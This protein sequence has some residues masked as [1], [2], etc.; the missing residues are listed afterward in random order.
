M[1]SKKTW[2]RS[3]TWPR[4]TAEDLTEEG[5]DKRRRELEAL[6]IDP[7]EYLRRLLPKAFNQDPELREAAARFR[8]SEPEQD[9]L[10][11]EFLKWGYRATLIGLVAVLVVGALRVSGVYNKAGTLFFVV[12][13]LALTAVVFATIR[14]IT[15]FVRYLKAREH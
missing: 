13:A 11:R 1:K 2:A 3:R 10:R 14:A 15:I 4:L 7:V 8:T 12:A 5:W 6:G 9:R